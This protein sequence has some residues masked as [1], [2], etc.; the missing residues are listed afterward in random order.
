MPAPTRRSARRA[1]ALSAARVISG[2]L[3]G[4]GRVAAP[5]TV[6]DNPER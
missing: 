6:V 4:T 5:R 2:I 1:V 3:I